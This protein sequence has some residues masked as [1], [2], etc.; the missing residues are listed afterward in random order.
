MARQCPLQVWGV[1]SIEVQEM[2]VFGD[3]T[4]KGHVASYTFLSI[5]DTIPILPSLLKQCGPKKINNH[6]IVSTHPCTMFLSLCQFPPI[7]A[8]IGLEIRKRDVLIVPIL[9]F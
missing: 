5:Q 7:A 2:M 1:D 8:F 9:A 4:M 6:L 3:S